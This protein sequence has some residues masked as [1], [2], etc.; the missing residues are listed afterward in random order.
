MNPEDYVSYPLALALK[1]HG[2]DEPCHY[3]YSVKM[4]LEPELSFGDP[5]MVHSKAPKN[6]N[7]NRKGIVKGLEFCSAVPLWQAQKWL[8]D[9]KG[10]AINV[11]AHGC[12]EKYREGKY[13][14]EEI[15]LPNSNEKGPQ[16]VDWFIYGKHPLFDTYEEALS[17]GMLQML[18]L[19]EKKE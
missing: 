19:I 2:F 7:D 12:H 18:E 5:K 17:D 4:R 11:I 10:I 3:G 15:H 1:K 16:W 14:W 6:Y 9:R 8:R 13:H